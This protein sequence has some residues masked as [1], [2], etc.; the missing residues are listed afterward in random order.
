MAH[1]SD[2]RPSRFA[3][4]IRLALG[5]CGLFALSSCLSTRVDEDPPSDAPLRHYA[6]F[7]HE[8]SSS[9]PDSLW[10]QSPLDSGSAQPSWSPGSR[11]V[12]FFPEL[13]PLGR[14]SLRVESWR[15]G[16]R[17]GTHFL[18]ETIYGE[19][20]GTSIRTTL[21]DSTARR[22]L[23]L[24]DSLRGTSGKHLDG[25]SLSALRDSL[26]QSV[27]R[28]AFQG[29]PA[30]AN[31]LKAPPVGLDTADLVRRSLD[32]ALRSDLSLAQI[33][34]RWTLGLDYARTREVLASRGMDSLPLNPF[35]IAAPLHL[36]T[37]HL[38]EPGSG[39]VGKISARLGIRSA[40]FRLENDSGDRTDRFMVSDAPSFPVQNLLELAGRPVFTPRSNAAVGRYTLEL[41]ATDSFGNQAVFQ[42]AVWVKGPLDHTGP[43]LEV[44][45]PIAAVANAFGD[46]LMVVHVKATDLSGVAS[47]KI[48]G[49]DASMGS[50]GTWSRQILIPVSRDSRK[51]RIE[52]VDSVGNSHD[53]DLLV[54]RDEPPVPTPPRLHLVAPASRTLIPFDS[55]SV[56][57]VWTAG[58]GFGR[59]DSVTIGGVPARNTSDSTWRVR[60]DPPPD[61]NLADIGVRAHATSGLA[62]TD[63]VSVGRRKD[64]TGPVVRWVSPMQGQRIGYEVDRIQVAVAVV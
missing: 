63:F 45:H 33:A 39:L 8:D 37:L 21:A 5:A 36:D 31:L 53:T 26:R 23:W 47:V 4:G 56:E 64:T 17:T 3:W 10:F 24:F 42:T 35:R 30:T 49:M 12:V 14:D 9:L 28:L 32:L 18:K 54:R 2:P 58:T 15:L 59:I 16:L 43:S 25:D 11:Q 13:R 34:Q 61:G 57:V 55:T 40:T 38:G 51:V 62:A 60:L 6:H 1:R 19:L 44:V 7:R 46:S 50:D 27:A 29:H 41:S 20:A 22:L 52:A 48:G